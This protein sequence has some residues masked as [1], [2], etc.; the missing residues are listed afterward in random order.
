MG[1]KSHG[2]QPS[3]ERLGQVDGMSLS[4]KSPI[5]RVPSLEG[6][7]ALHLTVACVL[8]QWLGAACRQR[9]LSRTVVED[10]QEHLGL[11]VTVVCYHK[12]GF[13]FQLEVSGKEFR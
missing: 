11:S 9:G 1:G 4:K 13:P 8:C 12:L 2:L 6:A 3:S 5:G 7:E 10:P